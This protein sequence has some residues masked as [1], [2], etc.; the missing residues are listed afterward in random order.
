MLTC[1]EWNECNERCSG[2]HQLAGTV[3][4][5]GLELTTPFSPSHVLHDGSELFRLFWFSAVLESSVLLNLLQK[6]TTTVLNSTW[7]EPTCVVK[8]L[9]RWGGHMDTTFKLCIFLRLNTEKCHFWVLQ[10]KTWCRI[11]LHYQSSTWSSNG[12]FVCKHFSESGM[13]TNHSPSPIRANMRYTPKQKEDKYLCEDRLWYVLSGH[14]DAEVSVSWFPFSDR[15]KPPRN[16]NQ[17]KPKINKN[18]NQKTN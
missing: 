14:P 18:P 10:L 15:Q 12:T 4:V 13:P 16:S 5:W 8:A 17:N 11:G 2:A 1:R 3:A 9:Q 7:M 6:K